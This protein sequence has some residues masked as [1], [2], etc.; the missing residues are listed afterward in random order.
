MAITPTKVALALVS[1]LL[2]SSLGLDLQAPDLLLFSALLRCTSACPQNSCALRSIHCASSFSS[3]SSILVVAVGSLLTPLSV[4]HSS[5]SSSGGTTSLAS[6]HRSSSSLFLN[7]VLEDY[8]CYF[9]QPLFQVTQHYI[10][11]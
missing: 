8:C 5:L 6:T 4:Y 7:W 2:T 1:F 11:L 3:W 10:F 9:V